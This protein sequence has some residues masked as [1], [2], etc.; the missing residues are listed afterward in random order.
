MIIKT[1]Q[2][3]CRLVKHNSYHPD[4][5][6]ICNRYVKRIDTH[7]V[8]F[9]GMKRTQINYAQALEDCREKRG[10]LPEISNNISDTNSMT[11]SQQGQTSSRSILTKNHLLTCEKKRSLKIEN[12]VFKFYYQSHQDLFF[13]FNS[14]L[15]K[16]CGK[17]VKNSK[18]ICQS[19]KQVWMTFDTDMNLS[20]NLLKDPEMIEDNFVIPHLQVIRRN[21][22]VNESQRQPVTQV[23]TI[24][25]K[26]GCVTNLFKFSRAR[27][28]F[29]GLTSQD[30][31]ICKLYAI[32][33]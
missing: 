23:S 32:G 10:K 8:I 31:E 15:I 17:T 33:M 5:C 30:M 18:Q 16:V 11:S 24:L 19:V 2:H 27:R 20:Q 1:A 13:D 12:D 28:C 4:L 26:L 25:S 21:N 29:F 6:T 22:E 3:I 14:W 9:H 7:L